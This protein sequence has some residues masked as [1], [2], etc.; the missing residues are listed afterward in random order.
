MRKLQKKVD[1]LV[2]TSAYSQIGI[3]GVVEAEAIS[4]S[5]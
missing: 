4:V 5:L 1:E 3:D 2:T